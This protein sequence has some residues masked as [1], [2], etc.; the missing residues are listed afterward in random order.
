MDFAQYG[1]YIDWDADNDFSDASEDI[2]PYVLRSSWQSGFPNGPPEHAN[3]GVCYLKLDNSTSIFS[4]FNPASP[5]YGLIRPG[6]KVRV[7][8]KI[9]TGSEITMWQGYLQ[10]IVPVVGEMMSI[11]T[12]ELTAY[13]VLSQF[14]EGE[15]DVPLQENITTGAAINELL[16]QDGFSADERAIDIGQSTLSKW[17]IR[18]GSSRLQA[19]RDLEDAELGRVREGRDGK[20]VFEDRR[21]F[22]TVT[23]SSTVQSTYGAGVLNLWNLRQEEPLPGIFNRVQSAVRTF[24]KSEDITLVTVADIANN[25]GGTPP[26]VPANGTLT[27]W[28]EYPTPGSP[29]DHIAVNEWTIVD[30]EANTAADCSGSD[31]TTDVSAV[32]TAY[33][34]KLRIDFSNANSSPAHLIVLRAHGT[35]IIESDPIPIKSEDGVS[36]AKYRKRSYPYPSQWITDLSDGQ[37]QLDFIVRTHKDPRPRLTFD[38]RAN[39]D[40]AHLAETQTRDVSD[41]IRV[42]AGSDFGLYIDAE[43]IV[44]HIAHQVDET[45]LHLMTVS[46]TLAP[47]EQLA[48]SGTVYA[49]KTIPGPTFGAEPH[50]PDQLWTIGLVSGSRIIFGAMARKWNADIS[51][52]EFRAKLISGSQSA[53][54]VDLKTE[55]EGGS[56]ADNGTTQLM[57]TGLA[58]SWQGVQ[59]QLFY[60]A[61]IGRWYFVFRLKNA[62]GWSVWSDGNDVPKYVKDY[63]DTDAGDFSDTGPPADWTVSIQA[64]PQTNTA[65]V[66]ASRPQTNARRIWFA[67]FQIKDATTGSWKALDADAGASDVFYDGSA[68]DH[69]YDPVTGCITKASGDYG[70]A[71]TSGGVI[72][73]DV[74]GATF[75]RQHCQWAPSAPGQYS[76]NAISG[77]IGWHPDFE[78]DGDGRYTGLRIKVVA[79]PWSWA[80]EGYMGLAG[81]QT[82][83]F[84]ENATRGD[85]SS[86]S[87][88]SAPFSLPAGVDLTDVQARVWFGTDYSFSDDDTVSDFTPAGTAPGSEVVPINPAADVTIDASLGK[89]FKIVLDRDIDLHVVNAPDGQPFEV[90]FVQDATGGWTVT[91][92]GDEFAE[93]LDTV[94]CIAAGAGARSYVLFSGNQATG[95]MDVLCSARG[96]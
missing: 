60:G 86:P 1:Y 13:G 48:A 77:Q 96:Y 64:G 21:R 37:A 58:A 66:V 89:L 10:S 71:A 20:F 74:R 12:A 91:L 32:K 57:V 18:K 26:I 81:Y 30:Y 54:Y 41:R 75:D 3:A 4:S 9:G 67:V 29:S 73:M 80:T 39:Y 31:I 23:R 14:S 93:G 28:I 49:P 15:V 24:N 50:V 85:L 70:D 92:P 19:I 47:T 7:T 94:F 95:V 90:V 63:V 59:Q 17:W 53:E 79:A 33:G 82:Q 5:L 65:V 56:F 62:A 35:A 76:G 55:A 88:K 45:R 11:S 69:T 40:L 51:E 87:F 16:D 43:F 36:Q 68:I 27:V 34:P 83:Y 61:N 46:C 22:F 72:L 6:L 78:P 38:L 2:S 44:D 52:A 8:M 84:A 25:Q 42:V